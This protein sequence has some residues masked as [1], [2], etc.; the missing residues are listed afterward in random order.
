MP[1]GPLLPSML[2]LK[3]QQQPMPDWICQE[4]GLPAASTFA[5]LD[6]AVWRG[7][8]RAS[9]RVLNALVNLL[10]S[11]LDD[12]ANEPVVDPDLRQD[13]ISLV[14]APLSARSAN[15]LRNAGLLARPQD[16]SELRIA[17]LLKIPALGFRSALEIACVVESLMSSRKA[18]LH[19]LALF[20]TEEESPDWV[21]RLTDFA[22]QPWAGQ[23]SE[24][25]L[26]FGHLLPTDSGGT[27]AERI[28]RLLEKPDA[29]SSLVRGPQLAD[30]LELVKA[31]TDRQSRLD[32]GEALNELLAASSRNRRSQVEAL[33]A[34]FG[35]S[36]SPPKTLEDSARPLGVSRERIRQIERRFLGQ[37]A[38]QVYMPQLDAAIDLLERSAPVGCDAGAKLLEAEHISSKPFSVESVIEAAKLLKRDTDL[39]IE[40]AHGTGR[41]LVGSVSSVRTIVGTARRLAGMAG[42]A[43]VFQVASAIGVATIS[44]DETRRVLRAI[45]QIEFLNEDWFWVTNIP[46]GRNRLSNVA[47]RILSVASPQA[48]HSVREG[49]RRAF[50]YRS[51]S[52]TRYEALLTPPSD[53]LT[54]FF[55]HSPDFNI[56]DGQVSPA[57][58]LNY[59]D[60]LGDVDKALVDVFRG[61]SS[62]VL[63]RR[64]VLEAC[65]R[66]G[67]NESSVS[68]ALTYSPI[69]EHVG[70]DIWKLRGV[71]VDPAAVEA[72]REA[73]A[74]E[75]TEQRLLNF[76]WR[77]TGELWVASRLP[78]TL[79]SM[80]LGLPGTT[81]R[82]LAG[83][84]FAATDG[85]S[86]TPCG[87]ISVN[88]AGV[89]FGYST[90]LRVA[91]AEP[92]DVLL[93]E[94][95]LTEDA[96]RLSLA[97]ELILDS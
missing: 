25:D 64:A 42:V 37:L 4:L 75:P 40:E 60:E 56:K 97:D 35:W 89:A 31:E 14:D 19:Q 76:G 21:Q 59:A 8:Q 33:T 38:D 63:D 82:Y 27:I 50:T 48:V 6:E 28:E 86:G 71:V 95:N 88:D 53:V 16:L 22:A 52:N 45:P 67:L 23:I 12:A 44:S 79:A 1:P 24:R 26:R 72:L 49:V 30:A 83:R 3:W 69:I 29:I 32:L 73:N 78:Y 62:G 41:L 13:S 92:G 51:K 10:R 15:A 43:S 68:V 87:T 34:R 55:Q 91:G 18:A 46:P 47:N 94:F 5:R 66:R 7:T 80:V 57:R 9:E 84:K 74:N 93:A 70:V 61:T 2:R 77:P 39:H 81:K 96:V 90:F 54:A 36:G 17:D 58:L 20:A 85:A 11:R 65:V